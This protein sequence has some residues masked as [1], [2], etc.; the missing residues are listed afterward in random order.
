MANKKKSPVSIRVNIMFVL[1]F[2]LFSLLVLRLGIVQIVHGENY[3][4]EIN[5]QR[6]CDCQ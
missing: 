6:R 2:L 1:I 4:R 5:R 3:Q